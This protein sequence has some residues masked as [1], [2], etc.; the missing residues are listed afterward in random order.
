MTENKVNTLLFDGECP[1]CLS[2][3]SRWRNTLERRG[4]ELA[5]LQTDWVRSRLNLPEKE[6]LNEMRLLTVDDT[7]LGAMDAYVFIWR[8]IWWCLPLWLI[9]HVPGVRFLM[10][11]AY[12]WVARNR[13]CLSGA[14]TLP[15]NSRAGGDLGIVRWLPL[16]LLPGTTIALRNHFTEKWI[17]M[18]VLAFSIYVGCKWLTL[19]R[20]WA[21]GLSSGPGRSLG[22][23]FLWPGM[24]A[25]PFMD[26][27]ESVGAPALREWLAACFK[28]LLG[29]SILW[30]LTPMI[31]ESR[32][33]LGAWVGMAGIIF[34][35]HFGSFHLV[36]L[37]WRSLGVRAEPIM[38][39]PAMAASLSSFWSE[40][41][42]RGFNQLAHDLVFRATYR[43]VGV[44][45]AILLVFLISGLVHDLVISLPAGAMFGLPTAYFIIQG[46]GVLI[47]RSRYGRR[48][49]LKGGVKGW[50]FMC[51]FTVGPAYWLFHKPFLLNVIHPFLKAIGAL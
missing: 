46:I 22:Y 25:K 17:F 4:F 32:L 26:D 20:A 49:G 2:L 50:V 39:S 45:V 34:M 21:N 36:A 37:A 28:F 16:L 23:L 51:I 10:N 9:A 47:E 33:I 14:C 31:G 48:M 3:V 30:G 29:V 1:F 7:V 24:D 38:R 5:P 42:N 11:R 43:R 8:K 13:M 35:L 12:R 19:A 44:G 18:W 40:R 15:H 41:W 6:L 27:A